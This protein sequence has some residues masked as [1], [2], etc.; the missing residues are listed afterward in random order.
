[1][2]LSKIS[3]IKFFH[4]SVKKPGQAPGTII[5]GADDET[6]PT[7]VEIISYDLDAYSKNILI[8]EESIE[9][10][11]NKNVSTWI[12]I[13]GL[14]DIERI[15]KIS[16]MFKLSH[17]LI[18]DVLHTSQRPKYELYG[19]VLFIVV[20]MFNLTPDKEINVEQVSVV[21]KKNLI[22][23]FQEKKGDVFDP[24]RNRI[25]EGGQRMRSM[26]CDYLANALLDTIVDYY[27]VILEE[28]GE[29][30]ERLEDELLKGPTPDTLHKINTIKKESMLLRRSLWPLRDVINRF[31]REESDLVQN[32]TRPYIRDIYD[33]VVQSI[34]AIESYRDVLSGMV[35]LY[36]SS[37][38]NKMN[39]IM[40][41]LTIIATI[42]IPLTFVAGIY[43]M[44]F[45]YMPELDW[46]YGYYGVWGV[47]IAI[48]L[49]MIYYFRR[50]KW[51]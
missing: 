18:E 30:I 41:V 21:I 13:V 33:H 17:L 8:N 11:I 37:V 40:K 12:N 19:D 34:E 45:K 29:R 16:E 15:K 42:F 51:F 26:G 3:P 31:E 39:A 32:E 50:K 43:G 28:V 1:M 47:I 2:K 25:K 23:T 22:I 48:V 14:R 44:N 10:Y 9:P 35:D 36:L 7:E 4:R 27:F 24:V 38:S 5:Q 46:H 20:K 49:V 6:E